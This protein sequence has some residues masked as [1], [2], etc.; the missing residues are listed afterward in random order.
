MEQGF[1]PYFSH[2]NQ[3]HASPT[4]SQMMHQSRNF[5]MHTQDSH[6][7]T[8]GADLPKAKDFKDGN[9]SVRFDV[10]NEEYDAT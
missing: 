2:I 4:G 3:P 9:K 8:K 7:V 10:F 6:D 1:K 5:A